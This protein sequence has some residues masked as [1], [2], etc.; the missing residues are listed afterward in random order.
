MNLDDLVIF[1]EY[2]FNNMGRRLNQ[3]QVI[4]RIIEVHGNTYDLSK[5][6]YKNTKER[7]KVICKVHDFFNTTTEQLF[8]GQGC[9]KCGWVNQGLKTRLSQKDIIIK[10]KKIHG[11]K[12]DY[13]KSVY[14]VT[15]KKI[16]IFCKKHGD[17]KQTPGSHLSGSGCPKCG[18]KSQMDKRKFNLE[19][20]IN[21][22]KEV[23]GNKYD[24]SKVNY[25]NSR[26]NIIII[27]PEHGEFFPSPGNH[28]NSKS[29]CPKCSI[30]EQHEDQKKTLEE[31]IKDSRKVHGNKYDYS[32]VN[33]VNSKTKVTVICQE[34]GEFYP[35]P[36]GHQ[37]GTGCPQCSLLEQSERLRKTL[38]EFIED[39]REVHGDLYDYS[40]VDY[41]NTETNVT[42]RCIKH[43]ELFYPT[44]NN[45][46]RGSG[47]PECKIDTLTKSTEDFVKDSI[48]IHEGLY[49]YSKVDYQK[50]YKKVI[51][52]CKKHGDFF[53]TPK[54]HLGGGGCQK[55]SYSKGELI[56]S[57]FLN[58]N[59]IEF[60]SQHRF[61]D[62]KS[63][64]K[65]RCDF[66]LPKDRI[67]IEYNGQQHYVSNDF[68]GG[69]KGLQR[70]Q[71]SDKL[72]EEY[73][74]E[75]DIRFEIIKF[76]EDVIFRLKQILNKDK[77]V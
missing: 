42:I 45:H 63:K 53:Q 50:N 57:N 19:E 67:V 35:N 20:F 38:E 49:D 44:P 24:Y 58:Q 75:N 70:V 77:I 60:I 14:Q 34:H 56:I 26:T 31:F 69:E 47:C 27:C 5:V 11:N 23:H 48:R 43:D 66:F 9:P 36:N 52:I 76:D 64:R 73:C 16:I 8:R 29:G 15:D 39:S 3:E 28:I 54:V 10:F 71:L 46:I 68:F 41:V 51:I 6:I 7:V 59:N 72:K 65:L 74:V 22:S 30:I 2:Y 32:K 37:R 25:I 12:Y 4:E 62:L 40:F 17:F 55:C 1:M 33:Y 18:I 13:S 21:K 61:K